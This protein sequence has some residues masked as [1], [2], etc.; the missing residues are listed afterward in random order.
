MRV[1]GMLMM[2]MTMID[3]DDDDSDVDRYMAEAVDSEEVVNGEEGLEYEG[4]EGLEYEGEEDL[5]DKGSKDGSKD[6]LEEE[7]EEA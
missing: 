4:E 1:L 2:M 5:F 7:E 6:V 3:D